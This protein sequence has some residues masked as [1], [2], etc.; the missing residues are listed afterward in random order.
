MHKED[1][2]LAKQLLSGGERVFDAFFD[3]YYARVYRFCLRRVSESEAEDIAL[4]TMRQAMRR[5]ET[6]R[7]EASLL[8]WL[9]QIARSQVSAFYKRAQKHKD[10]VLIEDSEQVQAQVAAMT[11][12]LAADPEALQESQQHKHLIHFMLDSLPGDY[13]RVLEWKYIEGFSVE[14]IAARL[15]SSPTAIQSMLARARTAF[16]RA[17]TEITEQADHS[18]VVPFGSGGA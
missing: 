10:L 7:G 6:Y 5:I 18:S 16:R 4:E 13:G 15:E 1:L 14:E 12:T 8:T 9:C 11:S 17:Y 2:K 3:Q